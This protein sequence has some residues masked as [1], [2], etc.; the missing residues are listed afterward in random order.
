MICDVCKGRSS[1]VHVQKIS[2]GAI[3][4]YYL[5]TECAVKLGY[6]KRVN[7]FDPDGNKDVHY[8][9]KD[10]GRRCPCCGCTIQD[11][12]SMGVAGCSECYTAF[13]DNIQEI[14]RQIHGEAKY[15]GHVPLNSSPKMRREAQLS[16]A[17]IRLQNA[18]EQ[19]NFEQAAV[20]RDFIRDLENHVQQ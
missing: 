15:S 4:D 7:Q 12:V 5:C 9:E 18:I 16:E 14:V 10:I 20:L 6:A 19:Q 17:R 1:S 13:R 8:T 3:T 11:V 2:A